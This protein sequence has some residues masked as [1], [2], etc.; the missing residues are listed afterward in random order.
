MY[1]MY[2]VY[3]LYCLYFHYSVIFIF[4]KGFLQKIM[5]GAAL[6]RSPLLRVCLPSA[7]FFFFPVSCTGFTVAALLRRPGRLW[8]GLSA[9]VRLRPRTSA[10]NLTGA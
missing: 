3:A 4:V 8:R 2:I 1:I 9:A 10:P 7:G 5:R 6:F